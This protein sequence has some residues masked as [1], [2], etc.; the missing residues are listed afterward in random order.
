MKKWQCKLCG[1]V[2]D[3]VLGLPEEGVAPGTTWDL[4]PDSWV[5]PDCG[6]AKS[7]FQMLELIS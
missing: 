7:E 1:F 2:Y 3:E 5:C 6:A 4:I